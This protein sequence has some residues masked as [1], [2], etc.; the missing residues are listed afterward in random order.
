QPVGPTSLT[1]GAGELL[2]DSLRVRVRDQYGNPVPGVPV[3]WTAESGSLSP[4]ADNTDGAGIS[5]TQW[6]LGTRTDSVHTARATAG[7]SLEVVFTATASLP[8]NAILQ[9]V[10]GDNQTGTVTQPLADSLVVRVILADGRPVGGVQITWAPDP[11]GTASPTT[12]ITDAAGRARTRWTLGTQAGTPTLRA[13]GPNGLNTPFRATANAGPPVA[14]VKTNGDGQTA[15]PGAE[16]PVDP[17]VKIVDQHGNG[18]LNSFVVWTVTLGGGSVTPASG[19]TGPGGL[20]KT[21]WTLGPAGQQR[22]RASSGSLA[23]VTFA[24]SAVPANTV[25]PGTMSLRTGQID[26]AQVAYYQD[27]TTVSVWTSLDSTVAFVRRNA[28]RQAVVLGKKPGTTGIVVRVASFYDTVQVTVQPLTESFVTFS[29]GLSTTCALTTSGAAYCWGNRLGGTAAPSEETGRNEAPVRYT[30]SLG[31]TWVHVNEP[32]GGSAEQAACA[33]NPSGDVYCWGPRPLLTMRQDSFPGL[34][35]GGHDWEKVELDRLHACGIRTDNTLH[36]WGNGPYRSMGNG[37]AGTLWSDITTGRFHSC[38]L[39]TDGTAWCWGS[40]DS[41]QLGSSGPFGENDVCLIDD[42]E[43][44]CTANPVPVSGG[45]TYT[46][47]DGYHSG[48]CALETGGTAWCWGNGNSSSTP[49]AVPGLQFTSIEVGS[50]G[51]CGV[52]VDGRG[53]CWSWGSAPGTPVSTTLTFRHVELGNGAHCGITTSNVIYCWGDNSRGHLGTGD[54]VD[55]T[56]PTRVV[57]QP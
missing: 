44:P 52:G 41:G 33:G 48:T 19:N 9:R 57:G 21:N 16:L 22:L 6:R 27:S 50:G 25:S 7:P 36:C 26:T 2:A 18:V 46:M 49:F 15:L 51:V 34:L 37:F 17:T 55:R 20:L 13:H 11:T 29:K 39:K 42:Y 3:T 40:D 45:R 54:T 14:I 30:G 5:Q 32:A 8:A 56:S 12:S 23:P 24:A 31:L 38:G 47:I 28:T 53:Y 35:P 43:Y 4:T 10:G 1:G